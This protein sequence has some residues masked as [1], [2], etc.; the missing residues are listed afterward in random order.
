MTATSWHSD[1]NIQMRTTLP[2]QSFSSFLPF[3]VIFKEDWFHIWLQNQPHPQISYPR[4]SLSSRNIYVLYL[5]NNKDATDN[6]IVLL[7]NNIQLLKHQLLWRLEKQLCLCHWITS[8]SEFITRHL[9]VQ[10]WEDF[11]NPTEEHLILQLKWKH[12]NKKNWSCNTF[13]WQQ[14]YIISINYKADT[15]IQTPQTSTLLIQM[16]F[17]K[18]LQPHVSECLSSGPWECSSVSAP[19]LPSVLPFLCPATSDLRSDTP[20]QFPVLFLHYQK[21]FSTYKNCINLETL[22]IKKIII[23]IKS[24]I[25]LRKQ[26]LT[27]Y[28]E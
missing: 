8:I 28:L 22:S 6:R 10:R 17:I 25:S 15:E 27:C 21:V 16:I 1:K 24:H 3:F 19:T 14:R 13:T 5:Q 20:K 2:A 9:G 11:L 12:Q 23:I 18:P 26:L 7:S 4:P